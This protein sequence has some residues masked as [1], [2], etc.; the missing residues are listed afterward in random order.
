MAPKKRLDWKF[1]SLTAVESS[2]DLLKFVNQYVKDHNFHGTPKFGNL[3]VQGKPVGCQI[4]T[5]KRHIDCKKKM[6]FSRRSR[7]VFGD[8]SLG[9]R[10]GETFVLIGTVGVCDGPLDLKAL[11]K[12]NCR[13]F[14]EY[15]HSPG[16]QG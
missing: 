1:H 2:M 16:K 15:N 10:D 5:C 7:A 4:A 9:R 3:T 14:A 11:K 13:H 8:L 6:Q 12:K